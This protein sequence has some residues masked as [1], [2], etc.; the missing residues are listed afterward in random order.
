MARKGD[1]GPY[2]SWNVDCITTEQNTKDRKK[3]TGLNHPMTKL[4]E[5]QVRE[6][7]LDSEM[8]IKE[9]CAKYGITESHIYKIRNKKIW[10][11]TTAGL[12]PV[13][14]KTSGQGARTDLLKQH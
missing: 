14:Y 13:T 12:G 4:T 10:L 7:Y 9:L 5:Q 1:R 3:L 6:I 8:K 11:A 2:A